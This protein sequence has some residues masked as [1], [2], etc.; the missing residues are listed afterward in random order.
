M[1]GCCSKNENQAFKS[2]TIIKHYL[3]RF[4]HAVSHL[5]VFRDSMRPVSCDTSINELSH[6]IAIQ[7]KALK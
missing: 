5:Y 1:R 3:I 2:R 6:A 4:V 7:K